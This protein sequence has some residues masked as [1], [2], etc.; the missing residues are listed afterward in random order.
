MNDPESLRSIARRLIARHRQ[1]VA[2][3]SGALDAVDEAIAQR[4]IPP[5]LRFDLALTEN[6]CRFLRSMRIGAE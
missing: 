5:A 3:R 4:P 1:R 6:D 2:E